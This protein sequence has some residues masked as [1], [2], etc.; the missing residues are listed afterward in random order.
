MRFFSF[1]FS[2][3]FVFFL[4]VFRFFCDV[5]SAVSMQQY[6]ILERLAALR[7]RPIYLFLPRDFRFGQ[8]L[9]GTSLLIRVPGAC[10]RVGAREK[11]QTLLSVPLCHKKRRVPCRRPTQW[12]VETERLP[13]PHA[14]DTGW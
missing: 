7:S 1:L 4:F 10:A 3:F 11:G 12:V 9:A 13:S 5:P 6:L 14:E 8:F 2:R